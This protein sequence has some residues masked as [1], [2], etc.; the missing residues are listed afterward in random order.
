MEERF[1]SHFLFLLQ[2]QKLG[3]VYYYLWQCFMQ[4]SRSS[5]RK[6]HL[7]QTFTSLMQR[8]SYNLSSQH[9]KST[10]FFSRG[11]RQKELTCMCY[12]TTGMFSKW[13]PFNFSNTEDHH[14][15]RKVC[16]P[17][18]HSGLKWSR[19]RLSKKVVLEICVPSKAQIYN[20]LFRQRCKITL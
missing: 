19:G 18:F 16:L 3:A 7:P 15:I 4:N 1:A 14:T 17:S 10:F 8:S 20:H 12:Y 6:P 9:R 13:H 2:W 11:K 5:L